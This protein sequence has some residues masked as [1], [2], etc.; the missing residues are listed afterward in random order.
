MYFAKFSTAALTAIWMM[1]TPAFAVTADEVITAIDVKI[2]DTI[3]DLKVL[4]G[5]Y[6]SITTTAERQAL[7]MNSA[8]LQSL[9]TQLEDAKFDVAN[10]P[11]VDLNSLIVSLH[12]DVSPH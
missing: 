1:A 4:W 8:A 10:D 2:D 9:L 6:K 3:D 7:L 5:G 12:L 11:S